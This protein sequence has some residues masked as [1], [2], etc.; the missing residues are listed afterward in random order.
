M[1]RQASAVTYLTLAFW[2]SVCLTVCHSL[3]MN[4]TGSRI[5]SQL[6]FSRQQNL[7]ETATH[8]FD[9]TL[10]EYSPFTQAARVEILLIILLLIFTRF[11]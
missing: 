2:Q 3:R 5:F 4:F 11:L 10:V 1:W 6:G 8:G 9:G 7:R